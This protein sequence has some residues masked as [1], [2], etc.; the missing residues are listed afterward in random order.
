MS[1]KEL[2]VREEYCPYCGSGDIENIDVTHDD[3]MVCYKMRCNSCHK[4][5]ENWYEEQLVFTGQNIDDNCMTVLSDGETVPEEFVIDD[6]KTDES[7][8]NKTDVE[9]DDKKD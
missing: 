1:K 3:N 7:S 9:T 6:D 5:F 4:I 2:T 8:V